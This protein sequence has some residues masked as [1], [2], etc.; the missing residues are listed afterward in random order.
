MQIQLS[1]KFTY[2]KLIKFTMPSILMMIII[3]I[4]GVVD[5]LF[6]SNYV[7]T[8]AFTSLN[9]IMPF[10][11]IFGAFGFM[12]GTGGCALVAKYL[13]ESN[14]K[15]AN[16]VFSMLIFVIA[17][18]AMLCTVVGIVFLKPI[19]LLMGAT[20]QLLGDCLTYGTILLLALPGFMLQTSFQTFVVVAN[21]P[22]MG[23]ILSILSGI[24]NIILDFL[25]I[26][27]FQWGI[28]GAAWATAISQVLGAIIPLIYFISKKNNSSLRLVK[29]KWD[30][31][32]LLKSCT[33]GSSE[34]MTNVSLSLI[35]M[36]YNI[37]LMKFLGING[38]SAYGIIMYISFIF[39]GVFIGYTI[40]VSPIISYHYGANNKVELKSLLKK[41]IVLMVS[42]SVILTL[43]AEI[44]APQ[45]S[46]IFVGYDPKLLSVS[47]TALRLYSISYLF[48]CIN[49]FASAFFTALN[50]GKISALISFLRT[51]VFQ[52]IMI[53]I[54]P[55][56]LGIEG[57]WL[58]VLFAEL[59]CLAV[60]IYLFKANNKH[61]GYY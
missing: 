22:N 37:Q 8:N 7:G 40:G 23:L 42:S 39:S 47:I 34:M 29:F 2:S 1:D 43:I 53:L 52:A 56:I 46:A 36:L 16:E 45:L 49:I 33:N 58:A 30:G 28:A 31:K 18:G 25:F 19:A 57:I 60:T 51:L 55:Y 26:A 32:A 4:Y 14:G 59:L 9:L 11:M 50:N 17:M 24:T 61:Y 35:N 41:S 13:G 12:L 54:L 44:F 15:K 20:P 48:S 5:G 38:V 27:I 3:S 10:I 21:K 6:V